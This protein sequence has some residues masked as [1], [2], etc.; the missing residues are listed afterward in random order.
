MLQ[1]SPADVR[2]DPFPHVV[3]DNILPAALY[4]RLRADYPTATSFRSSTDE[5]LGQGSRSGVGTGFD[6]YRGDTAYDRLLVRSSAWGELDAFINSPAFVDQFLH[7]FAGHLDAAG[8]SI[9]VAHSVHS[10]D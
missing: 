2:A 1:V 9:D 10:R 3:S 4:A 8:C 7:V 5:T 6:I